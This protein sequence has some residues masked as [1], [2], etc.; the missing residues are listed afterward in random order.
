MSLAEVVLSLEMGMI[1][2]IVA[3]G[4]YFTFRIIDF[5]DLTCDGSFILGACVSGVMIKAGYDPFLSLLLALLSGAI[6]GILT[7]VLNTRFKVTNLLSGIL[8]AFMLYSINLKIM[9]GSP[10]ITLMEDVTIFTDFDPLLVLGLTCLSVC[11]LCGYI[12]STDFGLAL[13]SI[14]QNKRL[15]LNGGVNVDRMITLGLAFG[16]ALI[17]FGGGLLSQHQGFVD[18]GSGVGTIIIGLASVMIGE[19]IFP[20]RSP[21]WGVFSCVAGS[22]VYRLFISFALHSDILGLESQDLNLITGLLV[23]GVM[24]LPRRRLC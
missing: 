10:N 20:F 16:N 23:I 9:G 11:G 8:V 19:K 13:R 22:V 7:G 2:G 18:V 21:W 14:G 15:A 1:Y 17:A 3:I 5:P 6:A 4:I 24:V 12:L